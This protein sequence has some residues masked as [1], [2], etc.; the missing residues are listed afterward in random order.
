MK[1]DLISLGVTTK[2]EDGTLT[3]YDKL[4]AWAGSDDGANLHS[5]D[6]D[7]A[8]AIVEVINDLIGKINK[9]NIVEIKV[10]RTADKLPPV[11]TPVIVAGGIAMLRSGDRWFSGLLEPVWEIPLNWEPKWWAEIPTENDI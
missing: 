4:A 6:A 7:D 9:A 11:F 1:H 3:A 8:E 10:Y 5:F 2:W